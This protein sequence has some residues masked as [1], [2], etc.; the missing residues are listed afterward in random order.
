MDL[1]SAASLGAALG[2]V[3]PS[4]LEAIGVKEVRRDRPPAAPAER[5]QPLGVGIRRGAGNGWMGFLIG[6][7]DVADADFGPQRLDGRDGPVFSLAI[8]RCCACP[9]REDV[10]DRFREHVVAVGIEQSERLGVGAKDAS[11]DAQ[12]EPAFEQIVEHRRVRGHDHGMAV[13]KIDHGRSDFHLRGRAQQRG[14]KHHAVGNVLGR[15]GEVLAAIAFAVSEPVGENKGFPILLERLDVA[16]CRGMHRHREIAKF[17]AFLRGAPRVG[18]AALLSRASLC[19]RGG[20]RCRGASR[21]RAG[22]VVAPQYCVRDQGGAL[23]EYRPSM[24]PGWPRTRDR[25]PCV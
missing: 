3:G 22:G 19:T 7:D 25:R 23:I 17:H 20:P 18:E 21:P 6:L 13:R 14:D 9:Q 16:P 10:V 11:A 24:R 15:V 8:D 1:A 5:D 4:A 12:D 2:V